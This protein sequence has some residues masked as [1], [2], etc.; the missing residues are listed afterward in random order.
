MVMRGLVHRNMRVYDKNR[1]SK[2]PPMGKATRWA[3]YFTIVLGAYIALKAVEPHVF[4]VV[5]DFRIT[6][7]VAEGDNLWIRGDF[8]KVRDCEFLEVV[9]YSGKQHVAVVFAEHPR[10]PV[11]S[12][13]VGSQ[14]YGPWLLVPRV[15]QIEIYARHQCF[16]GEVTTKLFDGAIAQ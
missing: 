10:A 3:L 14:T 1:R 4:P 6:E 2:C 13:L 15:P 12:R 11:V 5:K 9:A 7:V 8:N 16:T